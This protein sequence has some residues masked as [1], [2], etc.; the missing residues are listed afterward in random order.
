MLGSQELDAFI[1]RSFAG[2]VSTVRANGTPASSMVSYARFGDRIHFSTTL[3]RLKGKCLTR[4]PRLALCVVND[5]EPYS[6]ATVEGRVLIH[7]DNPKE[8][9][10]RM[11]AFWAGLV[12]RN[13]KS[14]WAVFG[15]ERLEKMWAEPGRAIFELEATRVSGVVM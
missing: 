10:E 2:I 15:R 1:S 12:E 8:L 5:Q 13:P 11:F 9:H 3:D 7:R 14:P 4:D 6:Y